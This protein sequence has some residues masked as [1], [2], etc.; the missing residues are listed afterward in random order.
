MFFWLT[1]LGVIIVDQASKWLVVS[2]FHLG[3]SVAVFKTWLHFTY[4]VNI[5]AAFGILPGGFWLFVLFTLIVLGGILYY[6]LVYHP[7]VM[8]QVI[9]GLI[10]GGAL[11][12][13]IDRVFR[14]GVVD[15][16]DLG[17]W[18]VFNIADSAVFC[19]AIALLIFTISKDQKEVSNGSN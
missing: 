6:H 5:G 12:N 4:V 9:T 16:I 2:H 1:A 18:P 10:A 8:L 3:E 17:W 11:G 13:F 7:P 14:D 19:G 15:F